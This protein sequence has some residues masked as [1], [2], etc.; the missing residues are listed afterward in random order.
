MALINSEL[1][2]ALISLLKE[3][4]R[5]GFRADAEGADEEDADE[6]GADEEG[7]E[8]EGAEEQYEVDPEY[9]AVE[10]FTDK[11]AKKVVTKLL[12]SR[13]L[14]ESAI[15]A[16]AMLYNA[17]Q[18]ESIERLLASAEARCSKAL[19]SITEYRAS[20]ARHLRDRSDRIIEGELVAVENSS[21]AELDCDN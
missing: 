15:E 8:E 5:L 13:G 17:R 14:D 11:A 18:L 12:A 3:T 4:L 2:N 10:W 21:A 19:R 9:L 20:F 6:E 16:R 7:A 1:P